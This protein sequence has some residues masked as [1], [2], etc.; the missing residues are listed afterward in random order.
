MRR[1]EALR[2]LGLHETQYP[3]HQTIRE[4]YLKLAKQH[5][6]DIAPGCKTLAAEQFKGIAN[7]YDVLVHGG[8]GSGSQHRTAAQAYEDLM[9]QRAK[10]PWLIRWLW[11][12]PAMRVKFQLKLATMV[13]LF[14]AALVDDMGR[15]QRARRSSMR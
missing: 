14:V 15:E 8:S 2:T 1:S 3:R 7:A 12:G 13:A 11:R 4:A 9:A 6:P 5:H 10:E